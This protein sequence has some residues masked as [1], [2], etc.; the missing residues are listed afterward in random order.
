VG[1]GGYTPEALAAAGADRVFPDLADT[2]AVL[3]AIF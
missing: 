1:T 3:R 2:E